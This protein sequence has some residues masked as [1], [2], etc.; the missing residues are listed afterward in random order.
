MSPHKIRFY[1][2]SSC[3]RCQI[4]KFILQR[5]LASKGLSYNTLVEERSVD[6]DRDAM[7]DLLMYNAINTPLILI[8]DRVLKEEEAV[9][10]NL[11]REAIDGWILSSGTQSATH[12]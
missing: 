10:E 6:N 4:A 3:T 12:G 2:S 5:V 7:A 11:I 1:K 8:G 9:K